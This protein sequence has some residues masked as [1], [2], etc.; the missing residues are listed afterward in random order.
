MRFDHKRRYSK[1]DYTIML[2]GRTCEIDLASFFSSSADYV[3]ITVVDLTN[4]LI[5]RL[6]QIANGQLETFECGLVLTITKYIF[7]PNRIN[8]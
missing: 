3:G 4:N 5:S 1:S 7:K 6:L 8:E 2:F